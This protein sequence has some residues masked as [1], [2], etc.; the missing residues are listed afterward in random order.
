MYFVS[1]VFKGVEAR[2]QK[3]EKLVLDVIV[4]VRKLRQYFQGHKILVKTNYPIFQ[5]LKKPDLAGRMVSWV[6]KVSK[7]EIQYIP[8]GSIKSQVMTYFIAE[9]SLPIDEEMPTK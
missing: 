8:R 2:Y 6:V 9:F 4:A 5:V 1:E 7:N 3:I